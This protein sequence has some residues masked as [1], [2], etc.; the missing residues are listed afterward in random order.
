MAKGR[1]TGGRAKGTPNKATTDVR[2]AIA[3]FAESNIEKVQVWLERGAKRNPLG[4]AKVF[5]MMLEYHVP[6]LARTEVTG[7]NGGPVRLVSAKEH[8]TEL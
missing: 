7:E 3:L 2:A 5:A 6:K 1:K 8:D 4:A